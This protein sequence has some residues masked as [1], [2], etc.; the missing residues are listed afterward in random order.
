MF[1]FTKKDWPSWVDRKPEKDR[2]CIGIV[3]E[4]GRLFYFVVMD[5]WDGL[6]VEISGDC[7]LVSHDDPPLCW[8]YAS[9]LGIKLDA[10]IPKRGVAA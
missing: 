6:L 3:K 5:G 9:G 10:H 8:Q 2:L 4:S 1:L 7:S